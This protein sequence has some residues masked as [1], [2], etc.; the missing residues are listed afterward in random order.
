MPKGRASSKVLELAL[1][2]VEGVKAFEPSFDFG[3]ELTVPILTSAMSDVQTELAGYV[4]SVAT[5]ADRLNRL[6]AVEERLND[7]SVRLLAAVAGK[8]GTDS[9][10]YEQAGGKRQSERRRRKRK[11][12]ESS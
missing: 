7:L 9:S 3:D 6:E 12:P 2:R 8:Y 1:E 11:P 10:E 5:T 4:Q